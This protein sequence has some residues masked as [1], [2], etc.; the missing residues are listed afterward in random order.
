M[1]TDYCF[2]T[3]WVK[4]EPAAVFCAGVDFGSRSTLDAALAALADVVSFLGA[5]GFFVTMRIPP[6]GCRGLVTHAAF[7]TR[8]ESSPIHGGA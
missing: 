3:R 1:K 7:T 5:A 6:K 2:F 4:A 8:M